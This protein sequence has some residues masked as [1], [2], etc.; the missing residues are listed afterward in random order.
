MSSDCKRFVANC[1]ACKYAHTNVSKQ[2]GLLHPLP[3][4][5]YPMQHL[6]MDFKEFPKD[7]NGYDCILVFIDRLSKAVVTIP[8]HKTV[9]SRQLAELFI[10]WIYRFGH[11][12]ESIISDRG[13][14]FVSSFWQEFCRIIGVKIKLS[15]AYHKQTD[16]Q[17]EIM[18]RY[19]DQRLRPFVN[20][21]QD[22]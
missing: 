4:P 2:Q 18:N 9:D 11:T 17:T 20:Y 6:C 10:Q 14:Q 8:C 15:T 7:R 12:P 3:I 21:Y 19:I 5:S 16:G 1:M 13:P 22:N